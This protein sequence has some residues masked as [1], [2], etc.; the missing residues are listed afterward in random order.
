MQ[1]TYVAT[2]R[3]HSLA[4]ARH[5]EIT[6]TLTQAKRAATREFGDERRDYTIV[7]G[8]EHDNGDVQIVASKRVGAKDWR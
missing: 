5:I 1:Q 8:L 2:I 3:H 4:R 6:G 7:I